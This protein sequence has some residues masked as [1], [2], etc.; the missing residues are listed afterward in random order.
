AL[1]SPNA[2]SGTPIS[3]NQA[4]Y[5]TLVCVS[6]KYAPAS[7]LRSP[8]S[9]YPIQALSSPCPITS[10]S[11]QTSARTNTSTPEPLTKEN[12]SQPSASIGTCCPSGSTGGSKIKTTL[13]K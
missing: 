7:T 13:T 8:S 1:K 2:V 4:V 9:Q 5:V 6:G 10:K 3:S 12:N 11:P